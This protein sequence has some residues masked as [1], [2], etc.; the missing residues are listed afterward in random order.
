MTTVRVLECCWS[1]LTELYGLSDQQARS[2]CLRNPLL[3]SRAVL[4]DM[5]ERVRFFNE[6]L[7]FTLPKG[8]EKEKE[9]EDNKQDDDEEEE[10]EEEEGEEE[11]DGEEE[12]E[13]TEQ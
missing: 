8:M 1:L 9:K 13:E 6:E 11:E 10:E 5:D 7:G 4:K 12:E 2:C 3:F